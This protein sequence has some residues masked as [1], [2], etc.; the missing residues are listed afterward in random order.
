MKSKVKKQIVVIIPAYNE[1][2]TIAGLIRDIGS[3]VP[4]VDILVVN[5]GGHDRTTEIARNENATVI[6]LP[7]NMGY[8]SALQTGYKYALKKGYHYAVQM[9]AD[10]QHDP[11][12]MP[13]LLS[14]I[15]EKEADVVIGSRFLDNSSY[16]VPVIRRIG[17]FIFSVI[18]S[19][20]IRQRITDPTSGYQALNRDAIDRF[21]ATHYYPVD[22]PDA[23][24]IIMLNRIG[25]KIKEIP[26]TMHANSQNKSMHS[27]L[28]VVYYVFKMTLSIFLTFLRKFPLKSS[29]E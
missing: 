26:V 5:D 8:G 17:I 28:N 29:S 13:N 10:G 22:F 9:D 1:E 14:V 21:Y 23:D 2:K 16:K 27:G 3:T 4:D 25:L 20:A 7:F 18:A 11:K 12:D 24:V 19:T 15:M 6:N